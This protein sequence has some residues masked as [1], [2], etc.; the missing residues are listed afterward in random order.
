MV[1]CRRPG[2]LPVPE[3]AVGL[4]HRQGARRAVGGRRGAPGSGAG[5]AA[6][7]AR[8]EVHL[9]LR[10]ANYDYERIQYNTVVSAGYKMLNALDALGADAPG[11]GAVVREGLVDPAA[12][13]L[14]GRAA[15][16]LGA[17][18]RPGLRG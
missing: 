3:A 8:R 2:Q 4:R 17:V 13:A 12:R 6:R 5:D 9:A 18:A 14:P 10:Q 1:R 16:R 7:A 15:H 11:A